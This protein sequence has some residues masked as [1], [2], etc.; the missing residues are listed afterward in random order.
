MW[1]RVRGRLFGG[2]Q[3]VFREKPNPLVVRA[4]T[5]GW[6]WVWVWLPAA[7]AVAMIAGESTDTMSA[8]HTSGWL[9]PW[10]EHVFGRFSDVL[11]GLLHH[12]ARKTGHFVGYGTVC[13][14]FVRGWLLTLGRRAGLKVRRWR[15]QG[16]GLGVASTAVVASLDEWHQTFVPSRTGTVH[17]VLLDTVGGIVACALVWTIY[18]GRERR[19]A[20]AGVRDEQREAADV[21]QTT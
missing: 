3:S 4:R 7:I 6:G 11:W 12:Y 2:M 14:T 19:M 21:E 1:S 18:A 13:L 20:N 9:R 15:L 10:F 16:N 17:D 5:D 8:S